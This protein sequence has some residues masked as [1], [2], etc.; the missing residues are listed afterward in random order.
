MAARSSMPRCSR[1]VLVTNRSSPTSWTRS[2]RRSV[3]CASR[4]NRPRP[5]RPRSRRSGT[6]RTAARTGRP[7]RRRSAW[8]LRARD[9]L[10][11]AGR[12]RWRRRRAPARPVRPACSRRARS[13]VTM[14]VERRAIARAGAA[15]SRPRRRCRCP[16]LRLL[17][18]GVQ[19]VVDLGA[20]AQA[21]GEGRRADRHD[22]ELLEIGGVLGV[23]AAIQDVHHR[24][25]STC[26]LTP[27]T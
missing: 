2:P 11:V 3:S 24:H 10:A 18:L 25:G 5:V 22:H 27:P 1:S 19:G 15:R 12:T 9:V 16:G 7:A 4:P 6:R 26:A 8:C 23:L 13:A 14:I 20:P 17:Q 21:L